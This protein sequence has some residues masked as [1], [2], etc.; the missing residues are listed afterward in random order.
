MKFNFSKVVAKTLDG[1]EVV[2]LDKFLANVLYSRAKNLT[3]VDLAHKI[4]NKK[5]IEVTQEQLDEIKFIINDENS[6]FH[7]FVRKAFLDFIES[8]K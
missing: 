7:A 5:E 4:H 8:A 2:D 6:G 1:T 3:L